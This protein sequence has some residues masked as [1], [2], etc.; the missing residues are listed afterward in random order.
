MKTKDV[1]IKAI[2]ISVGFFFLLNFI[3]NSIYFEKVL[4]DYFDLWGIIFIFTRWLVFL[5]S[6]IIFF[7]ILSKDLSINLS[8]K[9]FILISFILLF[10]LGLLI[11]WSLWITA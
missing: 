3:L 9:I 11:I 10:L 8:K 6:F 2:I 7:F 1:I 4:W 5:L